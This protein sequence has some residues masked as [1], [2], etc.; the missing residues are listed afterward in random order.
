MGFAAMMTAAVIVEPVMVLSF[1]YGL[2]PRALNIG[3]ASVAGPRIFGICHEVGSD[4]GYLG[5]SLLNEGS[6]RVVEIL[7]WS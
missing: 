1:M 2:T 5:G 4:G 3:Y 7:A 6:Q